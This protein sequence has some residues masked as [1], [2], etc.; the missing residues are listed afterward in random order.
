MREKEWRSNTIDY[1][2]K[3]EEE[4]WNLFDPLLLCLSFSMSSSR[5]FTWLDCFFIFYPRLFYLTS[6]TKWN[7]D[8]GH[9]QMIYPRSGDNLLKGVEKWWKKDKQ[10]EEKET[11]SVHGNEVLLFSCVCKECNYKTKSRETVFRVW[12]NRKME[13]YKG[14]YNVRVPEHCCS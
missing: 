3:K 12:Y 13:L 6:Y 14:C 5:P 10:H 4:K 8:S 2:R 7:Y 9:L 1:E 11:R